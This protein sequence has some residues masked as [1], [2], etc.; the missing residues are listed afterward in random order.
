M[1]RLDFTATVKSASAFS[2]ELQLNKNPVDLKRNGDTWQGKLS[3]D[4]NGSLAI[5]F[6]ATGLDGTGW[7]LEIDTTCPDGSSA[8]VFSKDDGVI[9]SGGRSRLETGVEIPADPCAKK[10]EA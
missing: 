7:S 6:G 4:L 1:R 10:K 3:V 5:L 9:K 8:K 2:V